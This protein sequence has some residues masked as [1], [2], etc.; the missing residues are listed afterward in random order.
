MSKSPDTAAALAA[1]IARKTEID[2]IRARL[3]GL[4]SITSAGSRMQAW[5]V[6][7]PWRAT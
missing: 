6:L 7:E 5:T 4:S 1:F 2:T 3:T